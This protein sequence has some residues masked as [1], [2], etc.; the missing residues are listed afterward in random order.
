MAKYLDP[1]H[2]LPAASGRIYIGKISK[3]K[4]RFSGD[5]KDVT[6]EFLLCAVNRWKATEET[7]VETDK[8]G[9]TRK[10]KIRCEEIK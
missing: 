7:I 1:L 4:E 6:E 10:F 3:N 9:K 2:L 8:N 5:K